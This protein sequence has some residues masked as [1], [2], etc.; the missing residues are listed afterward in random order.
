M[1]KKLFEKKSWTPEIADFMAAKELTE[2]K[3]EVI[4]KCLMNLHTQMKKNYEKVNNDHDRYVELYTQAR[5]ERYVIERKMMNLKA[6]VYK[7][8]KLRLV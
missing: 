5:E 2:E 4:K 1:L 3:E 7:N 8:Y 6:L